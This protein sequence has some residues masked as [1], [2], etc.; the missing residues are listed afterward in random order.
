MADDEDELDLADEAYEA[1]SEALG[2][3]HFM[4][5]DVLYAVGMMLVVIMRQSDVDKNQ[6]FKDLNQVVDFELQR[7]AD[8]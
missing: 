4:N 7:S 1:M 5:A 2:D 3:G 6:L 8:A